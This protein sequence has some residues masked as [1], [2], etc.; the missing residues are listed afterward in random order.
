MAA[1]AL[2]VS[3]CGGGGSNDGPDASAAA[4][5]DAAVST[6]ADA[7]ST[8]DAGGGST[9][10][11]GG[12][13]ASDAGGAPPDGGSPTGCPGAEDVLDV[14]T[15]VGP[16][17]ASLPRLVHDGAANAIVWTEYDG[18]DFEV[19]FSWVDAGMERLPGGSHVVTPDD[20]HLSA[21]AR[22]AWSGTEFGLVY[23]DDRNMTTDRAVY[24]ARLDATGTPIPGSEVQLGGQAGTQ[25]DPAVVWDP[26]NDQWGVAWVHMP[27]GG[28]VD[29][30]FARI[31]ANGAI[32]AGSELEVS[33]IPAGWGWLSYSG[34]SPLIWNG[35]EFVVVWTT[36]DTVVLSEIPPLGGAPSNIY[37]GGVGA[38]VPTRAAI[39]WDGARYGL[40]WMNWDFGHY[41]VH[42]ALVDAAGL[43][44]G[45]D[46]PLGTTTD[47]SGEPSIVWTGTHHAVAWGDEIV[48][49]SMTVAGEI[50]TALFD[51][52]GALVP[53][54]KRAL[55]CDP[56]LDW[57]S[58]IHWDGAS[59]SIAYEVYDQAA[60]ESD[61]R[62]LLFPS[63]SIP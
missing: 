51:A 12:A 6:G 49:P 11:A 9:P 41:R 57:F 23:A 28:D 20:G 30:H 62:V 26:V 3:G 25:D 44:A 21:L 22:I 1:I 16:G 17:N 55:T 32:V 59:L 45:T 63:A 10:D 36:Q 24:F 38:Q 27:G 47:Y 4:N 31:D 50:W 7:G 52:S 29:V 34:S 2:A 5:P 46:T 40:T 37:V 48:Q 54:S 14:P 39:A 13:V 15:V 56:D 60:N 42:F 58:T 61:A 33:T 18:A 8:P 35:S 19:W 53:G 43:V